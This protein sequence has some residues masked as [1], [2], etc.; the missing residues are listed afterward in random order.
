MLLLSGPRESML[1]IEKRDDWKSCLVSGRWFLINMQK[2]IFLPN[3]PALLP[4]PFWMLITR[5]I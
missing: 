4:I 3:M 5:E 1:G 2:V